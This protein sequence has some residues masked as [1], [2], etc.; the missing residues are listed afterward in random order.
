[1]RADQRLKHLQTTSLTGASLK[2]RE[3]MATFLSA[4]EFIILLSRSEE[5]P[6]PWVD[7]AK[8]IVREFEK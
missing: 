1:M 3:I 6:R 4:I 7:R 8:Q 2:D 5:G